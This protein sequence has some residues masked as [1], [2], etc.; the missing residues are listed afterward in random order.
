MLPRG[1]VP[2]RSSL[3]VGSASVLSGVGAAILDAE[4]R[5]GLLCGGAGRGRHPYEDN[6]RKIAQERVTKV[7]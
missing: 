5:A 3:I 6:P 2:P 1:A 7:R 4:P